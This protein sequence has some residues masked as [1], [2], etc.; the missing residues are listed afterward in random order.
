MKA[1]VFVPG[2][3]GT[4]LHS[5]EGEELWP[6]TALETQFGYGRV[7]KLLADGVRFGEIINKVMCFDFYGSLMD[8]FA[9]LEFRPGGAAKRLYLFPYDWRLDLEQTAERLVAQLDA[10]IATARR[11]STSSRTPWVA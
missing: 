9:D 2:I 5:A 11:R 7:D 4:K 10:V 8:Q 6:P 3:M 1:L